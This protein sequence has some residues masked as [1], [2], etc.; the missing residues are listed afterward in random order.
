MQERFVGRSWLI[1]CHA[2]SRHE[3]DSKMD[4]TIDGL[5]FRHF[6]MLD[7]HLHFSS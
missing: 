4:V 1:S 3:E 5:I 7:L 2:F 6:C